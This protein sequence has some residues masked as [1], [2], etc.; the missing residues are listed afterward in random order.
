[1]AFLHRDL[2]E[3]IYMH[4]PEGRKEPGKEEWV[5]HLNKTLYGLKQAERGWMSQLHHEMVNTNFQRLEANHCVHMRKTL[6]G[7]SMIGI[8]VDDMATAAS[9]SAEMASLI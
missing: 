7:S 3:E 1:M 6:L 4:Q 8:H 5:C 9:N 2:K